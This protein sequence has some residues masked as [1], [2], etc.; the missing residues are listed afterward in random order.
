[1]SMLVSALLFVPLLAVA[2][3]ALIWA[4][5]GSWPIRDKALLARTVIGRPGLTRVPKLTALAVGLIALAAGITALSLADQ[6]G[7][8]IWLTLAGAALAVLF[9]G[10]G[11]L[12][13]SAGWRA[14]HPEEPFAT[15]DRRNYAPLCLGLGAGFV[16]LIVMRLL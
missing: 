12:G 7:G 2:I 9:I 8:G 6:D 13:F 5:G 16:I 14:A 10:R 4:A 11:V 1:M 3:A 15:L